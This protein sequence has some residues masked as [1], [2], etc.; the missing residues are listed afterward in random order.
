MKKLLFICI[1]FPLLVRATGFTVQSSGHHASIAFSATELKAFLTA[2]EGF[3]YTTNPS[4]ADWIIILK[5]DSTLSESGF[6]VNCF[7]KNSKQYIELSGAADKD[8]PCAVYT[9]LEKL[10][11]TFEFDGYHLNGKINKAAIRNYGETITPLVKYRGIRQHIN[12]PMDISSYSLAD[13]KQYI[14]NLARMRFNHIVFHSY[15][16]Q[17]YEIKKKDTMEYAGQ[18][19]YGDRHDIPANPFIKQHVH[20]KKTFCIPEIEPFFDNIPKRSKMAV[21]WLNEVMSEAKRAGMTVQLSYEPRST[22]TDVGETI[23]ALRQIYHQY[24]QVDAIEMITEESGGWGPSNTAEETK[25]VLTSFFKNEILNDSIITAPIRP[26]QSD[27]GYIYGQIGH[28][29]KTMDVVKEQHTQLPSLKLGIYCTNQYNVASYHLARKY[30]PASQISILPAHGSANVANNAPL[31]LQ[32]GE[33]WGNTTIYSWLEF[34][35]M[36]YLQQNGIEG[37][38]RLV[39]GRPDKSPSV[40]LSTIDFNHWRTPENKITARYAALATLYGAEAPALFY[41]HYAQRLGIASPDTFSMA[42]QLLQTAFSSHTSNLGFAWMGAWRNGF[43][44][45]PDSDLQDMLRLYEAARNELGKCSKR[46]KDKYAENA[47]AF[48]DNRLRTT[49]I[50]LQAFIKANELNKPGIS[51]GEYNAVCNDVLN[52]FNECMKVYAEMMP[53]RGCEGTLINMYLSPVRA[54]KISRQK[55]TGVPLDEP[56]KPASHYDAPAPP[57]FNGG[58]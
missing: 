23:D 46:N 45:Q 26:V 34:D 42:M 38:Y 24:P 54:V 36:M 5:K 16:G 22:S 32:T 49:I 31:V 27:L 25:A 43:N 10:G 3:Y 29:L 12:F 30:L 14:R 52:L 8:I 4:K 48:L 35:G 55:K 41:K 6:S 37:I 11:Y 2:K 58:H 57:I 39:D 19:F 53:D 1:L 13:A 28:I 17:W 50:Y 7:A 20:N 51:H 56:L 47:I 40:R 18:F 21:H 44:F 9:L 15:P 33:N